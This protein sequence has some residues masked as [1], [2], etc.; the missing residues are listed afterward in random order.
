MDDL[1]SLELIAAALDAKKAEDIVILDLREESS[2]LSYFLIV[3]A[4]S[5]AHLRTL[6]DE[7]HKVAVE[8]GIDRPRIQAPQYES[9]WVTYDFGF[10]VIHLFEAEKRKFYDLEGIWK[11]AK[12][13]G[14]EAPALPKP[15]KE[16]SS[17]NL[18]PRKGKKTTIKKKTKKEK[19]MATAKKKPAKKKAA[20]KK[21]AKK[22][23]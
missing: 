23:K 22:K 8:N 11:K 3:T 17:N 13:V 15:K 10:F 4:L 18:K 2:Y 5:R 7:V 20:K 19:T 12:R 6:F 21:A 9:G 16:K 1:K 14:E